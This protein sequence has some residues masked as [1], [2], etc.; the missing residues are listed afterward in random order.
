MNR[1]LTALTAAFGAAVVVVAA[2]G[3]AATHGV[4]SR[5]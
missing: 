4:R 2:C 1:I 3:A 5:P